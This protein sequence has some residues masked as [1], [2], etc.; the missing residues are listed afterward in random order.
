MNTKL[1]LAGAL[2]LIITGAGYYAF[3]IYGTGTLAVKIT[4]P[5]KEWGNATNVYIHYSNVSV[6]RSG[7]GN[8]TG[9][10]TI[11]N[12]EGWLDLKTVLNTSKTLGS[13]ALQAGIYNLLRFEILECKV[14]VNSQNY[15]AP[16]ESGKMTVA[17]LQGGVKIVAGQTTS[18]MI[19]ITPKIVPHQ[20]GYKV[21]P[22][23]KATP[24]S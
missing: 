7:D 1:I 12:N 20:Q 24:E 14:T 4:D 3:T 11:V 21:V 5:P 16:V 13:G 15:T 17:I 2:V 9:W 6:H 18:V 23:A 22:A 19:D 10:Y 8:Q